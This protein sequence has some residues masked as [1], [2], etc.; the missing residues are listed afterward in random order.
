MLIGNPGEVRE[1][2]TRCLRIS[3]WAAWNVAEGTTECNVNGRAFLDVLV[4][5]VVD[6]VMPTITIHESTLP[7]HGTLPLTSL[8]VAI[9]DLTQELYGSPMLSRKYNNIKSVFKTKLDFAMCMVPRTKKDM[10]RKYP[11]HDPNYGKK[12][13]KPR[14]KT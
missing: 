1:I 8:S 11:E 6:K 7:L 4:D 14:G 10:Y 13:R 3:L 2:I 12:R 5:K 9:A